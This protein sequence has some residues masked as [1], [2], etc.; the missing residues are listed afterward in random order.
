MSV[1]LDDIIP[2]PDWPHAVLLHVRW[3]ALPVPHLNRNIP[4]GAVVCSHVV[5]SL[6]GDSDLQLQQLRPAQAEPRE[7]IPETETQTHRTMC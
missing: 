3:R 5:Q 1:D 7:D 2:F 6:A 4:F